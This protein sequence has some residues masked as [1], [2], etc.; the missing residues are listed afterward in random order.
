M[1]LV[2]GQI[3]RICD[4]VMLVCCCKGSRWAVTGYVV[5][6]VNLSSIYTLIVRRY[7]VMML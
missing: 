2:K 7:N 4:F 5:G 3:N 1:W 6:K